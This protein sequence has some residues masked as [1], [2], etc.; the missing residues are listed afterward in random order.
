MKQFISDPAVLLCYSRTSVGEN[1]ERLIR[2]AENARG[3]VTHH[4]DIR[5]TE[6]FRRK[7]CKI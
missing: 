1:A 7:L 6:I 2:K 5:D 4:R 3:G